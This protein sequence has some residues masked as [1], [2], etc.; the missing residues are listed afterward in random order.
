MRD[1]EVLFGKKSCFDFGFK[2]IDSDVFMPS[3]RS[4]FI[5]IPLR[6]GSF[7]NMPRKS[8]E[9][10]NLTLR[11]IQTRVLTR[12]ELR[13][14]IYHMQKKQKIIMWNEPDKYYHGE[15]L[16]SEELKFLGENLGTREFNLNFVC[17]PFA[18]GKLT[19]FNFLGNTQQKIVYRGTARTPYILEIMNNSDRESGLI[20]I[21]FELVSAE[22]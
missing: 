4:N 6:D 3:K 9:R 19:E 15:P 1:W 14:V 18:C 12:S 2:V 21:N 13:Y 10:R 16:N 11:C 8:F 20:N 22:D 17:D 7:D 5:E